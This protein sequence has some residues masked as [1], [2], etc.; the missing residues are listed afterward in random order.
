VPGQHRLRSSPVCHASAEH[1][2]SSFGG[3]VRS[4]WLGRVWRRDGRLRHS[5]P[6]IR[7]G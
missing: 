7:G 6:G 4:V 3:V 5:W 1:C 2:R